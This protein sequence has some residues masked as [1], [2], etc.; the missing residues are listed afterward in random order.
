VVG[1]VRDVLRRQENEPVVLV[2]WQSPRLFDS[3]LVVCWYFPKRPVDVE[4][5]NAKDDALD[6]S[7]MSDCFELSFETRLE[8]QRSR[9]SWVTTDVAIEILPQSQYTLE[10]AVARWRLDRVVRHQWQSSED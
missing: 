3:L 6:Q 10:L 1:L 8:A 5:L 4:G 9:I 7:Q 2:G